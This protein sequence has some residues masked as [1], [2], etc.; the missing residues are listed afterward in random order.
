MPRCR[1]LLVTILLSVLSV[2]IGKAQQLSNLR[3]QRIAIKADTTTLDSLSIVPG[4]VTVLA[5]G[6]AADSNAY[7]VDYPAALL[8]WKTDKPDSVFI[9]YRVFP[10]SF[11][12]VYL[13]KD[14]AK[15]DPEQIGDTNPFRFSAGS[16]TIDDIFGSDQLNK[17]GSISRGIA[18]G[19]NQDLS[20]NSTLNLELS[21]RLTDNIQVLASVTDDN[22]PIQPDGNTQQLQD[23]DQVFIQL[24]DDD[25]QLTAGDFQLRSPEDYFLKYYKKAKGGT[26]S[27]HLEFGVPEYTNNPKRPYSLDLQASAA[28]SRGKFAR[29]IIQGQEGN[30]GPYRL[31]GAEN[32]RF[33]IVLSGTERVFIDGQLLRRGQENDYVIDY[34]TAEVTFTANR[35]IT[36]DRRIVVEFQYSDNNYVRSLFQSAGQLDAGKLKFKWNA[37]SE[38]DLKNQPT[39]QTLEDS[40]K[41]LL[42]S[43]GDSLDLAVVP[44][45]T[46]VEEYT[47]E[48][49]LYTMIDTLG[50]DS[51]FLYTTVAD[52]LMFQ[53][54]FT[55]VGQGNGDYALDDFV[56]LGRVYK[57]VAPDTVDGQLV[58][59]GQFIP[60]RVLVAPRKRQMFSFGTMYDINE[61]LMVGA[62]FAVSV[63]DINTFS[64]LDKADNTGYAFRVFTEHKHVISKKKTKDPWMLNTRAEFERTD[65]NFTAI[66]RFRAVEF[67]RNWN[68]RNLLITGPMNITTASV[69]VSQKRAGHI[70]YSLH[71]F[72][73]QDVYDGLKN[74]L[75]VKLRDNG[76]FADVNGS[77]LMTNGTQ[78]TSFLR[79]KSHVGQNIKGM[80]I[81]FK[82][83]HE[84]NQFRQPGND[85]LT[86][87]SYQFYDW[88]GYI[89]SADSSKN[90]VELYYRQ[91]TDRASDSVVLQQSTIAEHYGFKLELDKNRSHKFRL[92]I[93]NRILH[94]RDTTLTTQ[95]P[96]NTLLG[97]IEYNMSIWKGA[98]TSTTFY[99]VGTGLEQKREFVYVEVPAGQGI[100]AWIDYNGDN[101]KDL[102]EFEISAFPDQALYIRVFTPSNIYVRTFSNMFSQTLR[103]RP[104][105]VWN[106]KEGFLAF[107][108]RFSTQSSFRVDRKTSS[109]DGQESYNPFVQNTDD[110]GLLTLNGSIRNS[111][112]FNRT[113]P[114]WGLEY[115]V[116]QVNGKVLLTNGFE[117]RG[118]YVQEGIIRWNLTRKFTL[119]AEGETGGKSNSSD[120]LSGRNYDIE[121][122]SGSAK[123][124]YQP[125][126]RM[127][128]S[129]IGEYTQKANDTE[130]AGETAI[131]RDIGG[132]LRYNV[133]NKGSIIA[134][135]NFIGISY[136]GL[137]NTSL[138][139]E[140]LNA[141]QPGINITWN[142]S[143]QRNISKFLIL[144]LNY[145]GRKSEEN[146]AI[147][148]GGMSV[149][150]LF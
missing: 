116:R 145:S 110:P 26:A 130:N 149:R 118:T 101:V 57:W 143:W 70:N 106:K 107:A 132:E 64:P 41:L 32:E 102:N 33:I 12:Q 36:K 14:K 93:A 139:F 5:N 80:V 11:T 105:K 138:A 98:V 91:R 109:D 42:N 3:S 34:N 58:H 108:G 17:S 29:N 20:V 71:S 15:A 147:H 114:E 141:L 140:M 66:E 126:A 84:N 76:F 125:D 18:F 55:D 28:A 10:L 43:I 88:Q 49:I 68:I 56:A 74:S 104:G 31:N 83:E 77:W 37:Y 1:L 65:G 78:E 40:D 51:V 111:V 6:K 59:K 22:I 16:N 150:A 50:Y 9:V 21:G 75:S 79:H 127:R 112:Y 136:T 94:V 85:S 90:R 131:L 129:I 54:A 134:Q 113:D 19:N 86:L 13:H 61:E 115:T 44:A 73:S 60:Q 2:T 124:S 123:F 137:T 120:F 63:F 8:V 24:F 30:Q 103:L 69:G 135:A 117:S 122:Y 95:S 46:E 100:Y 87:A 38:Q 133:I 121:Y 142:V 39:L 27:K 72:I 146:N 96:E 82:D 35:L 7:H 62:D 25:W 144:T 4:S 128:A 99:E 97:R 81:G 92:N 48:R 67:E 53:V 47:N 119:F 89:A 148:T 45:A 23:F 52:S